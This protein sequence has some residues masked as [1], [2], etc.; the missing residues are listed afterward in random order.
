MTGRASNAERSYRPR[1]HARAF[2]L[3]ELLIV[4]AILAILAGVLIPSLARAQAS[5]RLASCQA[6]LSA[7]TRAHL[8]YRSIDDYNGRM[9]PLSRPVVRVTPN[10][11]TAGQVVGQGILVTMRLNP[12]PFDALLCPAAPTAKRDKAMWVDKAPTSGCSYAY[13]WQFNV[14]GQESQGG[15]ITYE[16]AER[17]RRLALSMD[18][19]CDKG[20]GYKGGGDLDLISHPLLDAVN[21]AF[22]DLTVQRADGREIRLA[23]PGKAKEEDKWFL[24][25]DELKWSTGWKVSD[26]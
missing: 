19:N 3:V 21:I 23:A 9:P 1:R 8:L 15:A 14:P 5:A 20:T 26:P 6:N 11:R 7:Q 16:R 13:R 25:A 4:V 12:S 24:Q 22:I 10:V 18:V 17:E 2:T